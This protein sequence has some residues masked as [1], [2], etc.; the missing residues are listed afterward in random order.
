MAFYFDKFFKES[1]EKNKNK[2][3]I[4]FYQDKEKITYGK[5]YGLVKQ[6]CKSYIALGVNEKDRVILCAENSLEMVI[7]IFACIL[8]SVEL[9]LVP[10]YVKTAYLSQLISEIKPKLTILANNKSTSIKSSQDV[11]HIGAE[12]FT[13]KS[14]LQIGKNIDEQSYDEKIRNTSKDSACITVFTSGTTGY[15]KQVSINFEKI[16]LNALYRSQRLAHTCDD[17]VITSLPMFHIM[18][19]LTLLG[20]FQTGSSLIML[21]KF[22]VTEFSSASL[23][24]KASFLA[25]VPTMLIALSNEE[26]LHFNSLK[27]IV[28]AGSVLNSA[29]LKKVKEQFNVNHIYTE[30]GSS[31]TLAVSI[32]TLS[33]DCNKNVVDCGQ[34]LNGVNVKVVLLKNSSIE[35]KNKIGEILVKSDYLCK[36]DKSNGG[37][38]PT[39][40]LGFID[41]DGNLTVVGRIK[42][43]I[44]RGGETFSPE[45]IEGIIQRFQSIKL[46][47]VVG[48]PDN[49]YGEKIVAFVELFA[50]QAFSEESL[51]CF[52]QENLPHRQIPE[53]I[54]TLKSLPCTLNGKISRYE[55]K[56]LYN[57]LSL[58][59]KEC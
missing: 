14:F 43:T 51:K 10:S 59:R 6:A 16:F 31:E 13:L 20:V 5:M 55:L 21:K 57:K 53:E 50:G 29:L 41:N 52:L 7:N 54:I 23:E 37:W 56:R 39:G 58:R 27:N 17:I 11:I 47:K 34:A 4:S 8:L 48:V 19:L 42:E 24:K 18:G 1:M 40:D 15:R 9:V 46:A 26:N 12:G 38:F 45:E 36:D 33:A 28:V 32:G 35:V 25:C 44:I 22:N 3:F 49:Y 2:N 30:Y